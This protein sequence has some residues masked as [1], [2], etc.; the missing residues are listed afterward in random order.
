MIRR[1]QVLGN[2]TSH[3]LDFTCDKHVVWLIYGMR[4]H[5]GDNVTRAMQVW[6]IYPGCPASATNR[7][8]NLTLLDTTNVAAGADALVPSTTATVNQSPPGIYPIPFGRPNEIRVRWTAGG[9][10]SGG[11]AYIHLLVVE[12]PIEEAGFFG[13]YGT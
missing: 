7:D 6:L 4:V 9:A 5:N 3:N 10:S 13:G 1:E 8:I 2:N 12:I 11:T